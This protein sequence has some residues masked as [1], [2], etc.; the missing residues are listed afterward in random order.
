MCTSLTLRSKSGENCFARTMDFTIPL[1]AQMFAVSPDCEWTNY[2]TKGQTKDIYGILGAGLAVEGHIILFDGVNEQGLA[3]AMLYFTGFAHYHEPFSEPEKENLM[4]LDVL[5]YLLGKCAGLDDIRQILATISIVGMKDPYTKSVAPLHWIFTDRSGK[6]IVIEQTVQ[7]MHVYD[8]PIGVMTNSP[9][10]PWHLTNLNTFLHVSPYQHTADWN[11][12]QLRPFGQGAGT[13]ELPGGYTPPA[14]FARTAFQK[15][16]IEQPAD[17]DETVN[18]CFHLL[19]GVSIPKGVVMKNEEAD[20]FTRY[21]A[22]INTQTGNYYLKSYS[23]SHVIE[24]RMDES[25]KRDGTAR[26]LGHIAVPVRYGKL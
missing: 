13:S 26:N 16:H 22:V 5:R 6:S 21:T 11:G 1:H 3:G 2:V 18:A 9:D 4:A 17:N 25:L 20:D 8:N 23:N 14:R 15:T 10:F 12:F 7:G 19:E 24:V